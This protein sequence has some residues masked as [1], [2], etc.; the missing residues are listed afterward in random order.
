MKPII[1]FCNSP[2]APQ[3]PNEMFEEEFESA[4]LVGFETILFSDDLLA[5]GDIRSSLKAIPNYEY[6]TPVIY[7]GWMLKESV[8]HAL[9]EALRKLNLYLVNN[10]D[11]YLN[12]HYLPKAY[13]YIQEVTPKTIWFPVDA[14]I[15]EIA[16]TLHVKFGN[17]PIILKDYVKSQKHY[18][19]EACF[20]PSADSVPDIERVTNRFIELQEDE[21]VGGLVY[22]EFTPFKIIGHHPQSGMAVAKEIRVFVM[23]KQILSI[24]N[25]WEG[26]DIQFTTNE[27]EGVV[28]DIAKIFPS[29]FFTIDLAQCESGQW[30][31]VEVGDGQVSG[32]PDNNYTYFYESLFNAVN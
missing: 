31:I 9:F 22:R 2:V 23:D 16:A 18:W 12:A 21:L 20:I 10:P 14:P 8:Y 30:M 19:S 1:L 29:N 15:P 3:K 5:I 27:I 7:R 32:I 4:K 28:M 24:H 25:Y 17:G 6:P 26:F 13:P 11:E